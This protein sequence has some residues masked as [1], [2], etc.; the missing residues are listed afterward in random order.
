MPLWGD[1][2]HFNILALYLTLMQSSTLN[3]KNN[4]QRARYF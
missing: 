2:K 3:L 4:F 1:E